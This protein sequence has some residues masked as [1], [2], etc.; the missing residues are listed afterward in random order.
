MG[1]KEQVMDIFRI[2]LT[3]KTRT[4]CANMPT[5]QNPFD[6]DN[7]MQ[8]TPHEDFNFTWNLQFSKY[9]PNWI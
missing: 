2:L 4:S 8:G 9:F 3:Y 6:R 5:H 7:T 1:K